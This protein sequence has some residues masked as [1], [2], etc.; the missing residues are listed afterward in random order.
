MC[1]G[2]RLLAQAAAL[3]GKNNRAD[4]IEEVRALLDHPKQ[5]VRDAAQWAVQKLTDI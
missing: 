1:G 5:A 2:G 4:L 3:A